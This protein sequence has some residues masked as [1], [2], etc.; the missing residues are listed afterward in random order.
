MADSVSSVNGVASGIQWRDIVDQVMAI[1]TARRLTPVQTQGATD[2]KKAEAWRAFEVVAQRVR[3]AAFA[4]RDAS[5]FS[6]FK[7]SAAPSPTT[8]R[9]LV[10]VSAGGSA[11]PGSY[12]V[13]VLGLARA[14]KLGGAVVASASTALGLT[15]AFAV[16]GRSITV[17]ATDTITTLRDKVNAVNVG[18]GATGVVATILPGSD[19]ARLVLTST[20]TGLA[21]IELND[22]GA[23]TLQA[24]G[25]ADG[26]AKASITGAGLTRSFRASGSTTTLAT[27]LGIAAPAA[28]SILVAGQSIAIDL[29]TDSLASVAERINTA[30]GSSTAARVTSET[31]NGRTVYRLETDAAVDADGSGSLAASRRVLAALGLTRDGRAGV[32]QVVGS[33]NAFTAG[34]SAAAAGTLLTALG[35]GGAG[36]GLAVGDVV[37]VNG[38]RG[39]GTTVTRSLTIGAGTTL[40]DLL[41]LMNDNTSGFGAGTRPASASVNGSGRILLTDGTAG[42]SQLAVSV[43]VARAAGGTVSLGSF[44][45]ANGAVGRKIEIVDGT[46]AQLRVEGRTLTRATNSVTDAIDG[47]TLNLLAAEAGTTVAVTVDRDTDAMVKGVQGLVGAYNA[48]RTWVTTNTA[49]KAVLAGNSVVRSAM[50]TLTNAL[51]QSP[52]GATGRYTSASLVGLQH[53][54]N[55]VLA[56]DDAAFTT[57]LTTDPDAVRRLLAQVGEAS[58]S[59]VTWVGSTSATVASA[60]P[61]AVSITQAATPAQA[62]GAVWASYATAGAPDTMTLTDAFT[63]NSGSVTIANGDS[64]DTVVARLNA[65]FAT[66]KMRLAAVKT[67]DSRLRI[68]ASDPGSAAGFTIAYT[69]GAGGDGTAL[70]GLAAGSTA[71]LNVAGTI[72]GVAGTGNGQ[73]LTG[74]AG[75]ASEGLSIRYS[76]TTARAVGTVR[77]TLGVMGRLGRLVASMGTDAGSTS[78]AQALALTSQADALD[79]RVTDIQARLDARRQALVKQFTAMETAIAKAQS[80]GSTLASQLTSLQNQAG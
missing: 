70:L 71:G 60:T 11:T 51:I 6:L 39:D 75:D 40:Q 55:G 26:T 53:D 18:D 63:G 28:S 47:V 27:A 35:A 43:T 25:L 16:N 30:L 10:G 69:P 73:V 5:S 21:G 14:E 29:A 68:T 77:F 1:E 78:E 66:Q 31:F 24:L 19:G 32:A 17:A 20:Q 72:N 44:S 56:L 45:T 50:G 34:G 54:R 3:D 33:T 38:T 2:R 15:G 46:D 41:T 74:A 58:D 76:G 12:A 22:D 52:V 9:A 4:L 62:S 49:A 37:S 42:D 23:G 57:A 65:V 48:M 8:S 80:I 64:L 59:E 36:L 79:R 67:L 7:A 13:E 61:Y